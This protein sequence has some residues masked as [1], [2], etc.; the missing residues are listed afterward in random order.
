MST[1]NTELQSWVK[2]VSE[3]T[4]PDNIYWCN[5][6]K[7]EYEEFIQQMLGTG[8]LMKLNEETFPNCYLHRSDP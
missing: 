7:E 2:E 8:D 6:S 3:M 1:S 5:G 4:K